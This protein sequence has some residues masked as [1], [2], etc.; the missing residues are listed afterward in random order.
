MTTESPPDNPGDSSSTTELV[1]D[2]RVATTE[3][4]EGEGKSSEGP[5]QVLQSESETLYTYILCV[6]SWCVLLCNRAQ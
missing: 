6:Y 5:L 2:E 4:T 1:S 3:A